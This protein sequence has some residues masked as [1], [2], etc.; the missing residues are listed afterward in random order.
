MLRILA[1]LVS[2]AAILAVVICAS[3][4]EASTGPDVPKN[5]VIARIQ[6][7]SVEAPQSYGGLTIFPLT[8]RSIGGLNYL[9]LD[10]AVRRNV[11]EIVEKDGGIVNTV[12]VYNHSVTPVFIMDGEEIIGA[13]QNRVL[14]TSVLIGP[15]QMV[16]LPVS[17][18]ERGR[19][20]GA[21]MSFKSG[22]TQL[23]ARARQF[24]LA[25]VN[26]NL[27]MSPSGGA[28]SDQSRIWDH[29]AEKRASLGLGNASGPMHEAYAVQE[30]TISNYVKHF[31]IVPGQIGAVFAIRGEIIGADMFDQS[32]TLTRLFEKMIKSY[33]LDA[34]EQD[35]FRNNRLPTLG[36]V[37]ARRFVRLVLE[38]N[39]AFRDY[40]SPGEGRDVRIDSPRINGAALVA[41]GRPIHIA[42]FAPA[43]R[44][45]VPLREGGLR[46]PSQ[47]QRA[48]IPEPRLIR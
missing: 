39:V 29:V 8:A 5:L 10:E 16:Y 3:P 14:N 32:Q 28:R 36:V 4:K 27:A 41:E 21:S 48:T 30:P 17:C 47:R 38:R 44:E 2:T 33:A 13:K 23:F 40:D 25:A 22:G 20:S 35:R 15:K 43:K 11:I 18:V 34:I 45:P 31:H 6:E 24:N 26:D 42:L 19:W 1:I 12:V 9:T 46:P 37:E 7:L